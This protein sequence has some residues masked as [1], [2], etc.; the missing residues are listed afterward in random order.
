MIFAFFPITGGEV[1]ED[2]P[3]HGEL[4]CGAYWRNHH[5]LSTTKARTIGTV[6]FTGQGA[7]QKHSFCSSVATPPFLPAL[8]ELDHE[9][10]LNRTTGSGIL[11]V[12]HVAGGL[13]AHRRNDIIELP[14]ESLTALRAMS[15]GFPETLCSVRCINRPFTA[16]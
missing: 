6:L 15:R 11:R 8:A 4:V 12:W 2:G 10:R 3:K 16:L 9:H 13:A 7:S 1:I 14:A 5:T